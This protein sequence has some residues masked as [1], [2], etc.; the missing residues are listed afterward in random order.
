MRLGNGEVTGA[1]PGALQMIKDEIIAFFAANPFL[2]VSEEWLATLLCRPLLLV[3]EAVLELTA[4]GRL[5]K[6]RQV[7]VSAVGGGMAHP[8]VPERPPLKGST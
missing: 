6:D 2:M 3:R 4:E 7:L 1:E 8:D 5:E